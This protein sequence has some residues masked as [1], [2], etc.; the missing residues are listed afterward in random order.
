MTDFKITLDNAEFNFKPVQEAGETIFIVSA[1][2]QS[3][4]M[5]TDEEGYWGIWQ[6]VPSWIKK[7]EEQ[8]ADAIEK[9]HA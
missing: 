6:Q 1:E 4:R 3:F 8:L 5:I 7:L 9:Q 2:N